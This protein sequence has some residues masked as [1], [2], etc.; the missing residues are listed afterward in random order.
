[1]T[2]FILEG[3]EKWS[4]FQV[5]ALGLVTLIGAEQVDRVL[6]QLAWNTITEWLPTLGAYIFATDQITEPIPGFT[7]YNITDGILATDLAGWF[8]RWLLCQDLTFCS[9]TIHIVGTNPGAGKPGRQHFKQICSLA[10]GSMTIVPVVL[11]ILVG[12]WWGLANTTAML[13]SVLVRQII[14]YQNRLAL[15]LAMEESERTSCEYVKVLITLPN[16]KVV[17]VYTTRGIVI[18]CLLTT[19]RPPN[20]KLYSVSR[21]AGWFAF[22][23]HVISLGMASLFSQIISVILLISATILVVRQI[24][25]DRKRIG[26]RM[27]FERFDSQAEF[28]AA[29]Y[30]RLDLTMNE[31]DSMVLWNLFPH[32]SN[33]SWWNKYRMAKEAGDFTS[34]KMILARPDRPT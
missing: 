8:S 29:T 24:G 16:G 10:L 19:P 25:T 34:W 21:V 2:V 1:M 5:D 17:T 32:R 26:R 30:A 9:S 22:G 28:R 23:V 3:L 7:L 12:D 33:E 15:D 13:A 18:D 6:G 31:E 14:L 20:P 11:S 4:P 27:V